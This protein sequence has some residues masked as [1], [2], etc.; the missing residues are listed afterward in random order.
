MAIDSKIEPTHPDNSVR[1]ST[2]LWAVAGILIAVACLDLVSPLVS[3][4]FRTVRNYNEGWNAYW[5]STAISGG[6]LYPSLDA[7]ISNNYPPLSFF[8]VGF[9]G[10]AIG[11][12]LLAGRALAL[13]SLL[14]VTVNIVIWL[15]LNDVRRSVA[16]LSGAAFVITIDALAPGYIAMNDP[17]WFAH[18]LMTSAMVILWRTPRSTRRVAYAAILLMLGG[19]VKHLL[20]PLPTALAAWLFRIDRRAFWRSIAFG[21]ALGIIILAVV[22]ARYGHV[23]LDDILHAP[24]RLTVKRPLLVGSVVVPPLLPF[25][26]FALVLAR[27]CWS[28]PAARFV[29]IYLGIAAT[30]ALSTSAGDG[31]W[32]NVVFDA[33][34]AGGLATGLALEHTI[35]GAAA[36]AKHLLSNGA[37]LLPAIFFIVWTPFALRLDVD[38]LR[39][40]PQQI[41]A[42]GADIDFIHQHGAR[43]AACEALALCFWAGAPFNLD[44]F[45]FGQKLKTARVPIGACSRLFDGARYTI[46]QLDAAPTDPDAMLP[47]ACSHEIADHYRV[48]RNSINGSFLLPRLRPPT[49]GGGDSVQER[50]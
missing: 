44:F 25:L 47:P 9:L 37:V 4:S 3:L 2:W 19:W 48:A 45:N 11:D 16:A 21:A 23:F 15:R 17:Q 36:R 39:S 10:R 24:R 27:K 13:I 38:R 30:V 6:A 14:L 20:I 8:V 34:I 50:R 29:L 42:T 40:L 5:A 33:A 43:D 31:V 12:P 22:V 35:A 41:Q 28:V 18:A 46:I 49:G 1:T 26:F 32:V 7:L